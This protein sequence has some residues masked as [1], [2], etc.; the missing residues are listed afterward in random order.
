MRKAN[1][2]SIFILGILSSIAIATVGVG[3]LKSNSNVSAEDNT[4]MTVDTLGNLTWE[5]I[6]GATAYNVSYT[7]GETTYMLS[8]ERNTANVGLALTRA[9]KAAVQANNAD[10]DATNDTPASVQF[11]VTPQGVNNAAMVYTHTFERYIDYGYATHDFASVKAQASGLTRLDELTLDESMANWISS[12]MFKND[13]LT[14]GFRADENLNDKGMTFA[15]FGEYS[16]TASSY[17]YRIVQKMNGSTILYVKSATNETVVS[18]TDYNTALVK[19]EEY[20]LQIAVF[21]TYDMTGVVSGETVYY[22]RSVY[23]ENSDTLKEVGGFEKFNA[24]TALSSLKYK[25]TPIAMVK[26]QIQTEV[27]ISAMYLKTEGFD[28]STY[29]FSGTPLYKDKEAPT[30]LY[31]NNVDATMNWNK[32]VGA[33]SYKYKIGERDW[34]EI[35]SRKVSVENELDQYKTLGYLPFSVRA[36]DGK[37]ASYNLDLDRFYKSRSKIVDYADACYNTKSTGSRP[38][39]KMNENLSNRYD[40]ADVSYGGNGVSGYAY[41]NTKLDGTNYGVHIATKLKI[42]QQS[43]YATRFYDMGIYGPATSVEYTRYYIALYGDGTVHLAHASSSWT[44]ATKSTNRT[45]K[46]FYWRLQNITDNFQLGYTYYVTFGVDQVYENEEVVAHRITA[47]IEQQTANGLDREVVGILTYDNERLH[48]EMEADGVTVKTKYE[49]SN[50]PT[51][52]LKASNNY[53]SVYRATADTNHV[54]TFK[55]KDQTITTKEADFG[56][57]YDFTDV[58]LAE[59]A[60]PN[61]YTHDG[62]WYFLNASGVK[63]N[64][65][66][67][68]YYGTT[69]SNKLTGGTLDVC[70]NLTPIEYDVVFEEESENASKYTIE[71]TEELKAPTTIPVGQVFDGWYE[72]SDTSYQNKITSL[73]GKTGNLSLKARFVDGYTITVDGETTGVASGATFT[74]PTAPSVEN[75]TFAGWEVFN[76]TAWEEYTGENAFEPTADMQFRAVYDWTE[77]T[78]TYVAQG[79]TNTSAGVYT[80]GETTTLS[81]ATK[82]GYFFAGWYLDEELTTLVNDT[83]DLVGNQTL[84]AKFVQNTLQD[85]ATVDRNKVAQILPTPTLPNGASYMVKVQRGTED[86][87]V[88]GNACVFDKAGTYKVVYTIT[89]ETGKSHTYTT[90]Y[91]VNEKYFVNVHYADGKVIALEKSANAIINENEL[92][93]MPEEGYRFGG[94]YTDSTYSKAFDMQTAVT[95]DLNLYVKWIPVEIQKKPTEDNQIQ[96][97]KESSNKVLAGLIGAL[98]GLLIGGGLCAGFMVYKKRK[99]SGKGE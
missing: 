24:K 19:G 90:T 76:G 92:P 81:N 7:V 69:T 80:K 1:K 45:R 4:T 5:E 28:S 55:A 51:I 43:S 48:N 66:L 40:S 14:I 64:F 6:S 35:K 29:V 39:P 58:K 3:S 57:Q 36:N 91:T 9:A 30:G 47:L 73:Q 65:P 27:D 8:A 98:G 85:T 41:L 82:A 77:Y 23:E 67:T 87:A 72:T 21:D 60:I 86:V 93:Q 59:S 32:V 54:L 79:A 2:K 95:E 70:A 38:F 11:T 33:T 10:A 75:K 12:A 18:G 44:N 71:S 68:G 88:N 20:Y 62:S 49:I 50:T 99:E 94:V 97:E 26:N 42:T 25:T 96:I 52:R 37:I 84:Y 15:L 17:N 53:S 63:R 61:G 89:L 78:L 46:D 56:A 13:V 74:F 83:A 34:T 22:S 16:A 31:Y